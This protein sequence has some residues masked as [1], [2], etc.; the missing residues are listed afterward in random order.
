MTGIIEWKKNQTTKKFLGL[1]TKP[2]ELPGPKF[3][4]QKNLVLVSISPLREDSEFS[5]NC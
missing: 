1:Q 2:K 3:N 5:G 4:Q